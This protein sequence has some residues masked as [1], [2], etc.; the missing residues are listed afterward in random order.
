MW[1]GSIVYK[2]PVTPIRSDVVMDIEIPRDNNVKEKCK[3]PILI[4]KGI[5]VYSDDNDVLCQC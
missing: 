5:K 3:N 4:Q 1:N 2:A